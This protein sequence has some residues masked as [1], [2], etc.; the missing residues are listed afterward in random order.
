MP[1]YHTEIGFPNHIAFKPYFNLRPT[2]HAERE[3]D[4]DRY[5]VI[6]FPKH[7]HPAVAKVIEIE[8][9]ELGNLVKILARQP[10]DTKGSDVV[11]A[12]LVETK[13]IKTAWI[14]RSDDKHCTLDRARYDTP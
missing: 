8:T 7:F 12:F 9:D 2:L 3:A 1:L 4:R 14:N 13:Q 6:E 10:M 5:G 11:Y